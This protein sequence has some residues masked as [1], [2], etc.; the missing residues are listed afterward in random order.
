MNWLEKLSDL[1]FVGGFGGVIVSALPQH[2]QRRA[3]ERP[4]DLNPYN[5]ISGNHDLTR[6]ACLAWMR[7][8]FGLMCLMRPRKLFIANLTGQIPYVL[9]SM[10]DSRFM[11]FCDF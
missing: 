7:T 8:A 2:I 4:S 5:V 9:N 11:K 1:M 10:R 3:R 6:V